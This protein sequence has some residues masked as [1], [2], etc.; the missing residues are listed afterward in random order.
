MG[1]FE[2]YKGR[3]WMNRGRMGSND[4][5]S[6]VA[7]KRGLVYGSIHP[8]SS[9]LFVSTSLQHR[10]HRSHLLSNLTYASPSL[11]FFITPPAAS[12][13]LLLISSVFLHVPASLL[14]IMVFSVG[15]QVEGG[16]NGSW[17]IVYLLLLTVFS[18]T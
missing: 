14:L 3:R 15:R 9:V 11:S 5:C 16:L 4:G 13:T 2:E 1:A 10:L 12:T 18:P 6:C 8:L 7:D 17:V